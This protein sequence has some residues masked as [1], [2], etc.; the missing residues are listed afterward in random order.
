MC[1]LFHDVL[2][3]LYQF[4]SLKCFVLLYYY[5]VKVIE[6][7]LNEYDVGIDYS[8]VEDGEY[9]LNLKVAKIDYNFLYFCYHISFNLL[10]IA[11]IRYIYPTL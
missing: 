7:A 4:I 5:N 3:F 2:L 6:R 8:I 9:V 10:D 11:L 1:N